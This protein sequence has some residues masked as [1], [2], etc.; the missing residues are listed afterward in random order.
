M[1]KLIILLLVSFNFFIFSSLWSSDNNSILENTFY[2]KVWQEVISMPKDNRPKIALVLGGGGARGF[3]HIG[4]LQ[5]FEENHI[6]IDIITGTSAGAFIGALYASGKTSEDLKKITKKIKWHDLFT[7]DLISFFKLLFKDKFLD[8][9]K[10]GILISK[11]IEGKHFY[12]LNIPFACVAADIVTGEKVVL[13]DGDVA[14]AVCASSAIPGIFEPIEYKQRYLVDGGIVD[15]VP[16][17]V[18]K[19]LGADIIIAVNI[20]AD[21]TQNE[22]KKAINMLFQITYI[23][24]K[25]LNAHILKD[26]DFILLPSVSGIDVQSLENY[27]II[28]EEGRIETR[29]NIK[30]IKKIIIKKIYGDFI[31]ESNKDI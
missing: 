8:S 17:D 14:Q 18:A 24:G 10:M 26:A 1:K 5:V 25:R 9:S 31:Q 12:E 3:A 29:K 20:E 6:P 13:R 11:N 2:D 21:F 16:V 4:V 7:L 19:G 15:N 30:Q 23:Q 22:L 28:I 27:E